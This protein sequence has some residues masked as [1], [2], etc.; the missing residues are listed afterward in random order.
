MTDE[1]VTPGF[2]GWLLVL[3]IFQFLLLARALALLVGI[4]QVFFSGFPAADIGRFS[5]LYGGRLVL[6]AAF[7]SIVVVAIVLML[8]RRRAFRRWARIE[9]I[10]FIVLPMAELAWIVAAPKSGEAGIN[11]AVMVLM[12]IHVAVGTT[13]DRYVETSQRVAATFVR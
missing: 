9:M 2:K 11:L 1:P 13:W 12:V 10:G 5:I 6:N 3:A 4:G 7:V 8:F